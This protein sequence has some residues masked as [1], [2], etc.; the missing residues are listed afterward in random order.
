MDNT[1]FGGQVPTVP[2]RTGPPSTIVHVQAILLSSLCL[3]LLSAFLAMVSKQWLNRCTPV[4]MRGIIIERSQYRQRKLDDIV[5]W[6]FDHVV[7]SLPLMLQAA[8]L[9]FGYALSRYLWEINT[10]I[11]LVTF[12]ATSFGA[13]FCLFI[14]IAGAA[15]VNLR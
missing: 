1:T 11:A 3:S 9:L 5:N 8:L 4:K 10:T 14:V 15:A 6:Y 2:Q 7:R 12:C 13:L